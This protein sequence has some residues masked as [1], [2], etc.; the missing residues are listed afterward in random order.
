MADHLTSQGIDL[1]IRRKLPPD[2]L[3]AAT[4]HI[5]VCEACRR[6]LNQAK[7][8]GAGSEYLAADLQAE[9]LPRDPH[10][11]YEQLEAYV[12]GL[13]DDVE[14]EIVINHLAVCAFCST[15]ERELALLRD[16]L[17]T[18]PQAARELT[19]D[20]TRNPGNLLQKLIVVF[21]MR[22]FE[23]GWAVVALVAIIAS[24]SFLIWRSDT[25]SEVATTNSNNN[26]SIAAKEDNRTDREQDNSNQ[27]TIAQQNSN[28]GAKSLSDI[29]SQG[30]FPS[31]Y[32]TVISQALSNQAIAPPPVVRELVGKPSK[33]MSNSSEDVS[34]ALLHPLGTATIGE[35][36]TFRWQPLDGATD[37]RVF[38]LDTDF[39]VVAMSAPVSGTAWTPPV[40]FKR[41]VVYVWQ[42]T[43]T[44]AGKEITAPAA[45]SA[46][47]RFKILE[48]SRARALQRIAKE[49]AGSHLILGIVYA[50]NGLLDD[51]ER[52]FQKAIDRSQEASLARKLSESVKAM[53]R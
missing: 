10:L 14:R 40:A 23:V 53:R 4:S 21:Q 29:A 50:H 47:A 20:V 32:E 41:G 8:S 15:E 7:P 49:R 5:F 24:A 45:P 52:E 28:E 25:P 13:A 3:L 36:P 44:I 27:P 34:F 51:A 18:Y 17:E 19:K 1:F 35:R 48:Q 22:P 2:D 31:E 6:Q 33:L 39:N 26:S 12:D 43:A 46:E 11:S 37:Y 42:V 30:S 38:V 9:S 16:N